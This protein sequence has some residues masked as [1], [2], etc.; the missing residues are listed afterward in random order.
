MNVSTTGIIRAPADRKLPLIASQTFI[1]YD[2]YPRLLSFP[3]SLI[4]SLSNDPSRL[5]LY[6]PPFVFLSRLTLLRSWTTYTVSLRTDFPL[7]EENCYWDEAKHNHFSGTGFQTFVI[8]S[9]KYS[10]DLH[11]DLALRARI[12]L[13]AQRSAFVFV[14]NTYARASCPSQPHYGTMNIVT[15]ITSQAILSRRKRTEHFA[16]PCQQESSLD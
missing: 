1:L 11:S 13:S 16:W 10:K 4:K 6:H 7:W 8:N 2:E 15:S 9:G 14:R 3:V 12:S 5:P